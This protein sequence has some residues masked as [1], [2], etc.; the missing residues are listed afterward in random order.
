MPRSR[1]DPLAAARAKA[2]AS[3][4][5]FVGKPKAK[6]K[7]KKKAGVR[8]SR[9]EQAMEH[10]K[11]RIEADCWE[12]ADAENFVALFA[13]LHGEVY[14]VS[15]VEE[16][17]TQWRGACS[18]ARKLFADVFDSDPNLMLAFVRWV[19]NREAGYERWRREHQSH[20]RRITWRL[21]FVSRALL[22]DWQIDV[23]RKAGPK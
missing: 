2:A 9:I 23:T 17:R 4:S 6:A 15:P 21:M 16:M 20:G 8:R 11:Q 7:A 3:M 13:W 14:G 12:D 10:V 1:K 5:A 22:T 18:A 19:W